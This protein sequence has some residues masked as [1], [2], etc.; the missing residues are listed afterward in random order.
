[1]KK[2]LFIFGMALSLVAGLALV[3]G[4]SNDDKKAEDEIV[5]AAWILI[6]PPGDLGWSYSHNQGR[7]AAELALTDVETSYRDNVPEEAAAVRT[8][9]EELIAEGNKIIFA[10]SWGF[11]DP[12]LEL[13]GE[14]PDVVF[15]HCS[16]YKMAANM[17]NYF[18]RI[19]QARY[20]TGIVAGRMTTANQIGYVAAFPIPEV[21]RGINAFTLGVRS[22]NPTATVEV[23]WTET[24]YD[25]TVEGDTADSLMAAGCDV[26]A[27]HQD[28]TATALKAQAQG[29][30]A[31]G[32][33]SDMLPFATDTV[34]TSALW[35]WGPYYT[36]RIRAVQNGT[37]TSQSYWGSLADGAVGLGVYGDMVE[38]TV[39]DEVAV[40]EATI[41][42]GSW[43]VFDGPF[44]KQDGSE[45]ID[46]GASLTDEDMLGMMEFVEGV[47]G[48]IPQG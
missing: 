36:E 43:D 47:I 21:I 38:Q 35:N 23:M 7:L 24:W 19:Y 48:T 27:Q 33:H 16:G 28:S 46:A 17:S 10:T 29:A 13:A 8:A 22:V 42:D 18:G 9:I 14:N 40:V 45:W 2:A 5:K 12:T 20:L 39:R 37:W 26:L 31:V 11:M 1:M 15:E 4:C 34:L 3:A 25:P 41:A 30:Y 44:N 32:Y 6:S